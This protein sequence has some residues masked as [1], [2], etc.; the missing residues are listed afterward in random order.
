MGNGEKKKKEKI[1]EIERNNG[2]RTICKMGKK[3]GKWE[4]NGKWENLE[5]GK[6]GEMRNF[7]KM[8]KKFVLRVQKK[9][10]Y[11]I[12]IYEISSIRRE[13]DVINISRLRKIGEIR[14][15]WEKK[16]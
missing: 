16:S 4:K 12:I 9:K 6:N 5:N 13:K 7:V 8:E 10:N 2:I 15:K 14:K 3:S 1:C 11:I